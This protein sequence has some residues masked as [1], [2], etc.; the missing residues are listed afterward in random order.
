[1]IPLLLALQKIAKP[2][3]GLHPDLVRTLEKPERALFNQP[4]TESLDAVRP[5]GSPVVPI[6]SVFDQVRDDPKIA[7]LR[8]SDAALGEHAAA[9]FPQESG[10]FASRKTSSA[11]RNRVPRLNKGPISAKY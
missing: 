1:M 9:D 11:T 4:A 3:D 10:S 6:Q 5:D 2:G 7:L 8:I